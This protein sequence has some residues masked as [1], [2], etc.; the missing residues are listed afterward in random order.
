MF[1]PFAEI[2]LQINFCIYL[3]CFATALSRN[4]NFNI[5]LV[6][7]IY[8]APL[9]PWGL[10]PGTEGR[11][12][13]VSF[14]NTIFGILELAI[15]VIT[16]RPADITFDT[17]FMKQLWGHT[18]PIALALIGLSYFAR[19]QVVPVGHL[20]LALIL[21][22]FIGGSVFRVAAVYQIGT[23]A[24]KFDIAFRDRQRLKN[25]QLYGWVRHPS[26]LAMMVVILA[27]AVNTHSWLAGTLGTLTAWFG[28]QYR[29]H[30]EEKA[31]AQQFGAEYE[32]FRSRTGIWLPRFPYK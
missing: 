7:L 19:M 25:D 11:F 16:V 4:F 6:G 3:L 28:F 17:T 29:I 30:H 32:K 13:V 27:Y 5:I 10:I 1:Y 15:F 14:M 9:V 31:L 22:L 26:Y 12:L 8:L 2:L 24:F 21:V 20:E 23:E 18:L